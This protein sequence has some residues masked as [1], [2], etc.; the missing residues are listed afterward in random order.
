MTGC[1]YLCATPIGNL[2]D[3]TLRVLR[4]LKEAD[5]IAAEDTRHTRKLLTHFEIHKPLVRYDEHNKEMAGPD[6]VAQMAEGKV[7]ALVSDAGLPA[8][9]DPGA[10]LVRLAIDAHIAVVPLPGAS[11]SLT[12]LVA[13]GLDPKT[14]TFLGF[15]PKTRKNRREMLAKLKSDRHT[16]IFYEAPHRLKEVLADLEAVLGNRSAVAARELT[17]KHEEFVRGTLEELRAHFEQT[18]PRGEFTLLLAGVS[19]EIGE[20]SEEQEELLPL[21]E[22]VALLEQQGLSK[23]DAMKQVAQARGLSRRT[24]Y[25]ALLNVEE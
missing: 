10:D 17:K 18:E 11:A 2:E 1:L 21:P 16:L 5:L 3:I 13:S 15:L 20:P 14:F 8:I 12:A 9:S 19:E 25:Q 22:A 7:V 4:V 24:V 23:K 6:L